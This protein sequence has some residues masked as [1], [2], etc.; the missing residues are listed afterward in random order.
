MT[1]NTDKPASPV[2]YIDEADDAYMGF[3]SKAEIAV[4]LAELADAEH[5]GRPI[6]EMLR[7]M[8]PRIRDDHLHRELAAKLT[9][10][11][12]R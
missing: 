11:P 2:C 9:E 1:G 12:G 3:A 10:Q 4:F 8:L 6:D 7:R 5:A